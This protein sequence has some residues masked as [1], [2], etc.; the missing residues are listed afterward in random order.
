MNIVSIPISNDLIIG[1]KTIFKSDNLD[2]FI[3]KI[4]IT[5]TAISC[6][7]PL[8]PEWIKDFLFSTGSYIPSIPQSAGNIAKIFVI[9]L[10]NSPSASID[11]GTNKFVTFFSYAISVIW[12]SFYNTSKSTIL[13]PCTHFTVYSLVSSIPAFCN[14]FTL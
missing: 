12:Q 4:S 11:L 7:A 1:D 10:I 5:L 14:S 8:H 6:K 3:L 2:P 9:S 13:F